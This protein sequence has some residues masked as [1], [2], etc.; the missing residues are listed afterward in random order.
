MIGELAEAGVCPTAKADPSRLL[1]E[2][3]MEGAKDSGFLK[4][5]T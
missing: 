5:P 3:V 2:E 4:S 1:R